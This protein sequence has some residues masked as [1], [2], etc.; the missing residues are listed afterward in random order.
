MCLWFENINWC[1]RI[2]HASLL[3]Y[4]N[5]INL[6]S[7]K[8]V[9]DVIFNLYELQWFLL[10]CISNRIEYLSTVGF[11]KQ[12]WF[13]FQIDHVEEGIMI[14]PPVQHIF[15]QRATLYFAIN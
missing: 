5:V 7:A 11:Q 2:P 8:V 1:Y 12:A 15:N 3:V 14:P 10:T 6:Q 13:V 4:F 9:L